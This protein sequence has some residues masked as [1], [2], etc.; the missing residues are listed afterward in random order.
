MSSI[1]YWRV[2]L[3]PE[4]G[5]WEICRDN[6]IIAIGYPDYPNDVNVRRFRDEMNL[7]DKIVAYLKNWKIGALGTI[8]GE[9]NIDEVLFRQW[10][11]RIRKIQWNHRSF[12][13][14]DF[15]DE[16]SKDVKA[17]LSR[18]DTVAE[19]KRRQ[20]EEIERLVLSL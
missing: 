11:W 6:E 8:I 1:K 20:Y 2:I 14:W 7:G 3:E 9:Y 17:V 18:R 16:L 15:D 5:V 4:W 19:L 13:G 12:Y 10:F